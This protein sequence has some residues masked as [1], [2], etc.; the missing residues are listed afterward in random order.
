MPKILKS[1]S[2]KK[3]EENSMK[4]TCNSKASVDLLGKVSFH[5][6]FAIVF[7]YGSWNR[8]CHACCPLDKSWNWHFWF[9]WVLWMSLVYH[10]WFHLTIILGHQSILSTAWFP[11]VQYCVL[12][13]IEEREWS[14]KRNQKKD[15]NWF[16]NAND[17]PWK[18]MHTSHIQTKKVISM[19]LEMYMY[20]YTYMYVTTIKEKRPRERR[21]YN[22]KL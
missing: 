4:V 9:T 22:S 21:M 17:Q 8:M 20:I 13:G 10:T 5:C 18:N 2:L 14:E 3:Y 16:Y 19:Y 6:F 12:L 1:I 15:I 11:C 7:L